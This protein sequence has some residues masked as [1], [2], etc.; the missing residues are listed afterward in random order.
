VLHTSRYRNPASLPDG[1]VLIVGSG[2]SGCEIGYELLA[3]GRTVHLSVGRCAWAPRR[4]RGR[5]VV[6]WLVD[7][8]LMDQT[9][10]SLPGPDARLAGTFAVSGSHGGI[11]CNPLVLERAGARLHGRLAGYQAGRALFAP[12]LEDSLRFGMEWER[13]LCSRMDAHAEAAGLDLPPAPSPDAPPVRPD[14]SEPLDLGSLGA[15]L[16]AN[17]FRPSY[18]W[19]HAEVFDDLGLPVT[20]RGV[21]GVPGLCFVGVPWLHTRQSPLLLGV[22]ADAEHVVAA[23]AAHLG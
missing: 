17:G 6:R 22:G 1:D 5:E 21:T 9:A 13:E 2:Q 11:D 15:V 3:A 20:R 23:I 7:L 4:Y 14:G 18:G 8:G 16:L 19:V 12:D 10:A